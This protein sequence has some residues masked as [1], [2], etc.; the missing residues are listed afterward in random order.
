MKRAYR[1]LVRA[2]LALAL[3]GVAPA[4]AAELPERLQLE[5][6]FFYEG[7][8][9][10]RATKRLQRLP[11]GNY[12]HSLW[13]R[14]TGMARA[15]TS[16]EWTEEGEFKIS[17]NQILPLRYVEVRRG[18]KRAYE[19]HAIFDWAQNVLR[20]G[21][22]KFALAPG[23]QDQ[24]SIIYSFMLD[25]L[26]ERGERTIMVTDGKDIEQY[27]LVHEGRETLRTPLGRIETVMIKRLSHRQIQREQECRNDKRACEVDDFVIWVAPDR[28]HIAVK[29][30][31]RRKDQ[32]MTLVLRD[33]QGL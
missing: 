7:I 22:Q 12:N 20:V 11:N 25:P 29:L 19:R 10:G 31:K 3:G 30:Q 17:G 33:V 5:Y 24:G 28:H 1:S 32:T 14:P 4:Q 9:L 18:D 21:E 26:G 8:E 27:K 16:V 13:V 15:L 6:S 2:A 23:T